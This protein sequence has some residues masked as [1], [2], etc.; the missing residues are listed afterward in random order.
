M[1][2]PP[3]PEPTADLEEEVR[4]D[5][6]NLIA[7][8][9]YDLETVIQLLTDRFEDEP[10]TEEQSGAI[11]RSIWAERLTVQTEWTTESDYDRL[12]RAFDSLS[13]A[14]VVARMNFAC[15]QNCGHTEIDDERTPVLGGGF[16][17][18]GYTFFHQQD[19][20]SIIDDSE[21]FLAYGTFGPVDGIDPALLASAAAGDSEAQEQVMDQSSVRVGSVIVAA[22]E[23]E[24]MDVTWDGTSVTR[25][26]V[27]VT[28]W[29]KRLPV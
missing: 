28:D 4:D 2:I 16:A 3:S 11:V 8:G 21:L 1:T 23:A 5:A 25:I 12:A 9:F 13:A 18:W 26:C 19:A 7:G 20:E 6:R 22:L 15:C 14:G 10:F 27:S 29:R 17:E 24:G